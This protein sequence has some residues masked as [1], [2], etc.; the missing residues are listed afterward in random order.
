LRLDHYKHSVDFVDQERGFATQL[1]TV[2]VNKDKFPLTEPTPIYNDGKLY[3]QKGD[4]FTIVH[5]YD[6]DPQIKEKIKELYK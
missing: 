5:Q 2:W 3:N 1:G 6:R 4:E